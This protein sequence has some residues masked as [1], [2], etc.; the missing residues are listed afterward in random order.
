[1]HEEIIRKL[2]RFFK[3]YPPLYWKK[4][5]TL[6]DPDQK[7]AGIFYLTQGC[8]RMYISTKNGKEMTLTFFKPH[9]FFPMM[10]TLT[11][12]P[13]RY[14]FETITRTKG[15]EA[16]KDMVVRFLLRNPDVLLNLA[17]RILK[18][19]ETL[20]IQSENILHSDAHVRLVSTL[21]LHAKRFGIT[22]NKKTVLTLRQTH[23]D[24]AKE[25][26]LAR[27]TVSR[28][29]KNFQKQNLLTYTDHLITLTDLVK[30]ENMLP[31]DLT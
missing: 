16:P 23:M 10:G 31:R 13:N 18:G 14:Y 30:L 24:L 3:Q 26:G 7:P 22:K 20:L 2:D 4:N 27:E 25:T 8:V 1:M 19:L 28:I 6:I 17:S 5:T 12:S 9:A 15:Y 21:Y 29:M 11:D